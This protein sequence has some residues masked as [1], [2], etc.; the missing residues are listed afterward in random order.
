[1]S[2]TFKKG[3][4]VF[5]RDDLKVGQG[6]GGVLFVKE[7]QS[8]LGKK[9]FVTEVLSQDYYRLKDWENLSEFGSFIFAEEMLEKEEE[10]R[11]FTLKDLQTGDVI[12]YRNS[13]RRF[14]IGENF[15]GVYGG[16]EDF[17]YGYYPNLKSTLSSNL[18]IMKVYRGANSLQNISD[19]LIVFDRSKPRTPTL[20][21]TIQE[22]S[23]KCESSGD[24]KDKM[25][26]EWLTELKEIRDAKLN[27]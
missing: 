2:R 16:M 27:S 23:K 18:D 17:R 12:E 9:A 22:Y 3:D 10:N 8:A 6:Y 20:E 1:M 7:M 4:I 25:M 15:V 13:G 21:E 19:S 26:F 5:V 24:L 11:T 14:V